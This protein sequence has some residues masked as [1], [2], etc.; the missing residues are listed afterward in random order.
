[1][2]MHTNS[3]QPIDQTIRILIV[4]DRDVLRTQY[5]NQ[6]RQF[7]FSR[8]TTAINA[9]EAVAMLESDEFRNP[10]VI[11]SDL[12]ME[13]MNGIEFVHELR[14][15]KNMTPVIIATEET[16]LEMCQ[17]IQ[18]IGANHIVSTPVSAMQLADAIHKVVGTSSDDQSASSQ[19]RMTLPL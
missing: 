13:G 11:I 9:A 14:R 6:L 2:N 17:A 16:S 4:E 1:M 5:R 7:G 3:H 18:Q 10:D 12:Y 15:A 19:C 8:V